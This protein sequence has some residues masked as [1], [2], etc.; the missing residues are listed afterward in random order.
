ML[1]LRQGFNSNLRKAPDSYVLRW[2]AG[3]RTCKFAVAHKAGKITALALSPSGA[4]LASGSSEGEVSVHLT[5]GMVK[6]GPRTPS[7]SPQWRHPRPH[8]R[9]TLSRS[10]PLAGG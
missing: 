4:I 9:H 2:D 1:A 10:N 3:H 5:H 8:A 7:L 6:V